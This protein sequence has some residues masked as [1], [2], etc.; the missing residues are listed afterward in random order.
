MTAVTMVEREQAAHTSALRMVDGS[1]NDVEVEQNSQLKALNQ[2]GDWMTQLAM[3]LQRMEQQPPPLA[4]TA[5]PPERPCPP[6][7]PP[8]PVKME[9][10]DDRTDRWEDRPNE[11][12][13]MGGIAPDEIFHVW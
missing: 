8:R 6:P 11:K 5:F 10:T 13:L 4:P 1:A 9:E 2:C 12:E 3:R 7:V